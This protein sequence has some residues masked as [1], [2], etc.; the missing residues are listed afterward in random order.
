MSRGNTTFSFI[1]KKMHQFSAIM[2]Y[3]NKKYKMT[4][5]PGSHEQGR[6]VVSLAIS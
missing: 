3:D 4:L 2:A 1:I 5:F 6:G